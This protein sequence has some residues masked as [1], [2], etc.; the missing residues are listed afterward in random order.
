MREAG[1]KN[2]IHLD[3]KVNTGDMVFFFPGLF[4]GVDPID[5]L[6]KVDFGSKKGRWF[7]NY[8]LLE[9]HHVKGRQTAI[10]HEPS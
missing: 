3:S 6:A 2:K 10:P 5:P 4:H 1:T 8:N 7:V 9:S